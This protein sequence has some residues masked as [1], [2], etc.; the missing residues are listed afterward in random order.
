[1]INVEVNRGDLNR[2]EAATDCVV[3]PHCKMRGRLDCMV[4]IKF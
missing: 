3:L 2:R 1:M 4:R